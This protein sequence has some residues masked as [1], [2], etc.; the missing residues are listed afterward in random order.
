M[1]IP[2]FTTLK[3]WAHSLV[4]DFP[5]DNIPILRNEEDWKGW[6]NMLIQENSF[7]SAGAPGTQNYSN[8]VEWAKDVFHTMANF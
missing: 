6:G 3:Q 1:M 7:S 5:S 8:W 4:I 2:R